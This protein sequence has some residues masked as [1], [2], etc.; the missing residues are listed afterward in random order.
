MANIFFSKTEAD[1][2]QQTIQAVRDVAAGVA[3]ETTREGSATEELAKGVVIDN[4]KGAWNL[5]SDFG[6]HVL[7]ADRNLGAGQNLSSERW[8]RIWSTYDWADSRP[9]S[10]TNPISGWAV[11]GASD[12]YGM[13][14]GLLNTGTNH[15]LSDVI[16][17]ISDY[18]GGLID[19]S[20]P[21]VTPWRPRTARE[22][23]AEFGMVA[24]AGAIPVAK[25]A[26][27]KTLGLKEAPIPVSESAG[28]KDYLARKEAGERVA[29]RIVG[30]PSATPPSTTPAFVPAFGVLG[31]FPTV[32]ALATFVWN[33]FDE[34]SSARSREKGNYLYDTPD[35]PLEQLRELK[36]AGDSA[37]NALRGIGKKD[38]NDLLTAAQSGDSN[39]IKALEQLFR[40]GNIH[41]Q[42][43]WIQFLK[44]RVDEFY[45][46]PTFGDLI[47]TVKREIKTND[48]HLDDTMKIVERRVGVNRGE[49]YMDA[50][51]DINIQPLMDKMAAG[52]ST[53]HLMLARLAEAGSERAQA[54]LLQ[55]VD[56]NE[57]AKLLDVA[58]EHPY[59][60]KY[61]ISDLVEKAGN[62]EIAKVLKILADHPYIGLLRSHIPLLIRT[63]RTC[64]E[65]MEILL[66][67]SSKNPGLFVTENILPI[68]N[69]ALSGND[70][71][72][73]VLLNLFSTRRD[74]FT[75][76]HLTQVRYTPPPRGNTW[77]YEFSEMQNSSPVRSPVPIYIDGTRGR[78]D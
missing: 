30:K 6:F 35:L 5:T 73:H 64:A 70:V 61:V 47:A 57:C 14:V 43:A 29:D 12:L 23:G 51:R 68:I 66:T 56:R 65:A 77:Y 21:L 69:M 39:A 32:E 9:M 26:V 40:A 38:V 58:R 48:P 46:P 20:H 27:A 17:V 63:A 59:A 18:T 74:L 78:N 60:L 19:L 50:L 8:R 44:P 28:F 76:D 3:E 45:G 33:K 72:G 42:K 71:A 7:G 49:V 36:A 11:R 52:D 16:D 22:I 62:P 1:T 75:P 25:G 67:L 24:M 41:A 55:M 34:L 37:W 13:S 54:A 31:I 2:L 15:Y 53:A 10:Q 4:A